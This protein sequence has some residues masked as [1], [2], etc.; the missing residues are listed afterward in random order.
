MKSIP[1]L[2]AIAA[3]SL[4]SSASAISR[5]ACSIQDPCSHQAELGYCLRP[6]FVIARDPMGEE[7]FFA[8]IE[9]NNGD[10]SR[11]TYSIVAKIPV[12]ENETTITGIDTDYIN[13]RLNAETK[14]F[15][16]V[17]IVKDDFGFD[18]TCR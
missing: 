15:E 9:K 2:M 4:S 14:K 18:V 13:L 1:M 8:M 6:S 7:G 16:G 12:Q 10:L 17:V 3:L 5:K 11:P